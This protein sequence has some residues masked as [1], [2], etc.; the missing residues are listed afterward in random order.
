MSNLLKQLLVI[1]LNQLN[2]LNTIIVY[3]IL[4]LEAVTVI[5]SC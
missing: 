5:I 4:Q 1:L 3:Y 2:D